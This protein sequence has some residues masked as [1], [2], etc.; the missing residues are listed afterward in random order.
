MLWGTMMAVRSTATQ[1][2]AARAGAKALLVS[3]GRPVQTPGLHPLPTCQNEG[4]QCVLTP[5]TNR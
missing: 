3:H 1:D 5:L 4:R 2:A